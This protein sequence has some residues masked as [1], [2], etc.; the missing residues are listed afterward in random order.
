M[1]I[2]EKN[3]AQD[4]DSKRLLQATRGKIDFIIRLDNAFIDDWKSILSARYAVGKEKRRAFCQSIR[5]IQETYA[6]Y[7]LMFKV[8]NPGVRF[9]L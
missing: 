5:A 3:I 1:T 7:R 9:T 8:T 4:I 6:E 2:R